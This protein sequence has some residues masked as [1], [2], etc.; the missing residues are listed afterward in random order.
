MTT[1]DSSAE[2]VPPVSRL[3]GLG[4]G[5]RLVLT[6]TALAV[7]CVGLACAALGLEIR[8]QTRT[9]LA[10]TLDRHQGTLLEVQTRQQTD[11]LAVSRLMTESPTL[12]AAMETYRSERV[13]EAA[14]RRDLLATVQEELDRIAGGMGRDA[15]VITDD[16][17]RVLA[18][19]LKGG[20]A[21]APGTSLAGAPIIRRSLRGDTEESAGV[22]DLLDLGGRPYQAAC[23]PIVLQGYTIG[24]LVVGDAVDA[25]FAARL[26][27]ALDSDVVLASDG[28]VLATTLSGV[29]DDEAL[30]ALSG[31]GGASREARL[32]TLDGQEYVVAS[33]PLGGDGAVHG[34]SLFLLGSLTRAIGPMNRLLFRSFLVYGALS[35]A[36]AGLVAWLLSRSILSPLERFIDFL[37]EVTAS[38][39]RGRRFEKAAASPEIR[40]LQTSYG[41]LMDSLDDYE[42]RRLHQAR[43]DMERMDRLKESEKLAAL[44]RMLSGAAHEINNPLTGV[45]GNIELM[46]GDT[47]LEPPVRAR[48]EKVRREGH[49]IVALVRN[50]LKTAHRDGG[51]RAIVD[52]NALLTECAA[53]RQHD[54]TSTGM[55]LV[56]DLAHSKCRV[57]GGELELQQVFVNIINNAYDALRGSGPAPELLI[58]TLAGDEEIGVE[59]LD[60]GPGIREPHRVFEHFYTTK[61]VGKGTGLGLS[62]S[63]A[64]VQSHGGRIA[65]SNRPEGG[66]RFAI[67][68]PALAHGLAAGAPPRA[69]EPR[70]AAAP[71]PQSSA[72]QS[73][74]AQKPGAEAAPSSG[75]PSGFPELRASVLVVDDEPSVLELE[76]TILESA[77]ATGIG[78]RSG[79][80]AVAQLQRRS[81]DLVVSDLKM[82]GQ[83][84]GEDLFR[85]VQANRP[86]AARRFVFVTGDTV[87]ET[88]QQFL[89]KTGRRFIQKPFS[90]DDYLATLKGALDERMAA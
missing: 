83:V 45:L 63:H 53:L 81:F 5:A 28:H 15:L 40:T 60:N 84:S 38:G 47:R 3:R 49:R 52:L 54:F 11:L 71:A 30:A 23:V 20:V 76:L 79:A 89:E 21:P 36:L 10:R 35:A 9:L 48:L 16:D 75:A 88:T 67:T 2:V 43:D 85:W 62:I 12:R 39:D 77:G 72:M 22:I 50:L 6:C 61:E 7:V 80:E 42:R 1:A 55:R 68:L 64:I 74:A 69:P 14:P 70:T 87:S 58:R 37:R 57:L 27:A 86:E 31:A 17:G 41:R 56:L 29:R 66:A 8:R 24:M 51:Q 44:G 59:F 65:A 78:A 34:S 19:S 32:A 33:L 82:P 4:L 18:A 90:I 73:S 26:G 25:Q 13:L 46:L